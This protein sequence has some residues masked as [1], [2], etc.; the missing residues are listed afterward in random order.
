M[1]KERTIKLVPIMWEQL[2]KI[3]LNLVGRHRHKGREEK[4]TMNSN[5]EHAPV[6]NPSQ[7][8]EREPCKEQRAPLGVFLRTAQDNE[9]KHRFLE[10]LNDILKKDPV[11]DKYCLLSM[12]EPD[13]SISTYELDRIYNALIGMNPK[14]D[15]H[16]L[17][18]LLSRGGSIE[19]AYQ[20]SKLCKSF[21]AG[22]FLATVP[23]Q[24]K[25]AATLI[26]LGADEIHIGPLGQLGPIDPQ[27][28]GLPA[29]GV[30]QALNTIAT[31]S[32]KHPG[33]ADMFARYLRLAL[34]VEQIGYCDRISESA[35]QYAERLLSAKQFSQERVSRIARELVHEY[36]D[37]GFVIDLAEAQLHLGDEWVKTG[38]EELALSEKVYELFDIYNLFLNVYTT[39]RLLVVGRLDRDVQVFKD[40]R[41]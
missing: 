18:M 35:V 12:F 31:L 38:T 8:P 32:E 20:I 21:S 26:A 27:V 11:A 28:G 14:K 17:L 13:D 39:K 5:A 41:N 40:Q 16:V 34:T 19:P 33:S 30:A 9:I 24:A 37:H 36:K 3:G 10:E 25:S 1:E 29:L 6:E 4:S 15:K 22:K 2:P 7:E 23:R